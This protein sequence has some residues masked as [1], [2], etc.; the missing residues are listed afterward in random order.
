MAKE[1]YKQLSCSDIGMACGFQVRAKTEEEVMEH[2]K[3]HASK[4]HGMKEIPPDV[5]KKIKASIKSVPVDIS[6]T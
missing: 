3:M 2:A 4:A 6:K 5:A 1:E